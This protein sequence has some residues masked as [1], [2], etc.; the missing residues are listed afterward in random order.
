MTIC[1]WRWA[2][3]TF[4]FYDTIELSRETKIDNSALPDDRHE[5]GNPL[6]A[7]ISNTF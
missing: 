3:V 5:N 7:D 1:F 2:C 4:H 6:T